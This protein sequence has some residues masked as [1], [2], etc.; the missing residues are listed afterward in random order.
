MSSN[1]ANGQLPPIDTQAIKGSTLDCRFIHF[2]QQLF[3]L[4]F[5]HEGQ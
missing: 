5:Q 2:R 3:W 4:L 1:S